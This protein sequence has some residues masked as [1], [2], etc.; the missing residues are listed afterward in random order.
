MEKAI[1]YLVCV[2]GSESSRVALYYACK[3]AIKRGGSVEML[4]VVP[5]ADMQNLFGVVGVSEQQQ[6]AGQGEAIFHL[7][8]GSASPVIALGEQAPRIAIVAA[9]ETYERTVDAR[10][11]SSRID[12][13]GSPVCCL[14]LVEAIEPGERD[15]EIVHRCGGIHLR[16]R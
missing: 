1:K 15:T 14:R 7:Q 12:L 6:R 3:H 10:L 5:P 9:L 11:G 4:H 13:D 2:D 16:R 8:V